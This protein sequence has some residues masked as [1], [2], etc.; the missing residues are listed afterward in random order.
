MMTAEELKFW[1]VF[2]TYRETKENF[3]FLW[4]QVNEV[5]LNVMQW[6]TADNLS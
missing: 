4:Q 1:N 6:C 2:I 5:F 3:T